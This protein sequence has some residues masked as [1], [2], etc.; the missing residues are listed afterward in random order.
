MFRNNGIPLYYQLET[1]L[2]KAILLGE[3]EAGMRLPSEDALARQ[4]EVSRITVR[5]AL[6]GLEKDVLIIRRRG[7]GTF[8]SE[9]PVSFE[10]PKFT[11]SIEDLISMG[12]KTKT[13]VIDFSL[14]TVAKNITD[15][16]GL[17]E[18][19]KV[20]RIERLRLVKNSPFSYILNYLP[21]AIGGTIQPGDVL[22]KPLLKILE[23]DL[24]IPLLEAIQRIEADAA[25]SY[26]A[27]LLE[28][29]IGDPL[30]KIQR[31]I[32][33]SRHRAVEYVSVLYRSDKY[34]YA[35][36]LEREEIRK[37]SVLDFGI[38]PGRLRGEY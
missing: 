10:V 18:G 21:F 2:R 20:V 29:R 9:K 11:G 6:S 25:D 13:K 15:H 3:I 36:K 16:L 34:Y 14:T 37:G 4:Y 17:P 23:D 31:I 24:H 26:V 5:R 1:I 27:P 32:F 19:S 12:I 7:K 33:D 8:V 38:T 35:V 28:I 30:L 22:V